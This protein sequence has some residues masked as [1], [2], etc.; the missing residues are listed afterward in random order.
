M[1]AAGKALWYIET[2]AGR[3]LA[4]AD[5]A[6]AAGLS[7]FHLSRLFHA[8]TGTSV[9]RYLRGRRLSMAAQRLADGADEILPV[10]MDAGYSTHAAFTR[11]FCEQFG[12]TPERVRES[13]TADLDLVQAARVDDIPTACSVAPR[14]LD[15]PSFQVAGIGMRHTRHSS[16]AIPGQWAQ[17]NR[18]WPK[19]APVS[20][21]VCHD[22][23]D[24]GGFTYLAA[25]PSAALTSIP[26]HWQ[27]LQIPARRYLV[28]WHD[29]HISSIRATWFWLLD[30]YLPT[31]GLS[32]AAA[33][34]LERYDARFD[35]HSGNGGVEIWLPVDPHP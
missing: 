2:H 14:L 25:L 3:P 18:E 23:D 1:S 8:R 26:A 24:D 28:A 27:R 4:L 22:S 21:G 29:G 19:P 33:P 31:S 11:A 20:F 16:G 35:E 6:A 17:L 7:P 15:T 9:M 13:G 34:D 32:L 5:I 12:Q 10:A 30:H